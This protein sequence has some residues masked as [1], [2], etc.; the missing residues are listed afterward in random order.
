V[1][2]DSKAKYY[3]NGD[4]VDTVF[5]GEASPTWKA[6]EHGLQFVKKGIIWRIG[7]GAKEMSRDYRCAC[8]HTM[9]MKC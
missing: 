7:S 4:L 1:C 8:A 9:W 5:P 3:P 2:K 6:I